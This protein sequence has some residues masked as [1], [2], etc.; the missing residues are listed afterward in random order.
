MTCTKKS[1]V[2]CGRDWWTECC[3]CDW[4]SRSHAGPTGARLA[5]NEWQ[6]HAR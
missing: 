3:D 1:M 5:N 6:E 4:K 2:H